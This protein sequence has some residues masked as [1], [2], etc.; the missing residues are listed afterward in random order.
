[1]HKLNYGAYAQRSKEL[2]IGDQSCG[3]ALC[4]LYTRIIRLCRHLFLSPH[5]VQC[6]SSR[7]SVPV[8][9]ISSET[10]VGTR[11]SLVGVD[12]LDQT[13]NILHRLANKIEDSVA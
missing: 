10:M 4:T 5:K 7:E 13:V 11:A 3:G 2:S 1:M 6:N 9:T 12:N 8:I